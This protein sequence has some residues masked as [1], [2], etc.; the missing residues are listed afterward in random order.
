[1]SPQQFRTCAVCAAPTAQS[2]AICNKVSYC[3]KEHQKGDWK[4]HKPN[5]FPASVQTSPDLGRYL[6]ATRSIKAGELILKEKPIV[7]GPNGKNG[8]HPICLSCYRI[9]K[10]NYV[11]SKCKWPLCSPKCENVSICFLHEML[12]YL[13]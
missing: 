7:S 4:A 6:A 8:Y 12:C 11:C 9:V 1:M 3:S 5:C 10:T 2:C 13:I